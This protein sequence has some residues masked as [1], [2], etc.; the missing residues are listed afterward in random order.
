M[1]GWMVIPFVV[2]EKWLKPSGLAPICRNAL[3]QR[4]TLDGSLMVAHTLNT[5]VNTI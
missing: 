2:G 5:Y 3:Q 4:S 1:E